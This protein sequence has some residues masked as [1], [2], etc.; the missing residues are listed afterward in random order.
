VRETFELLGRQMT[1]LDLS[2]PADARSPAVVASRWRVHAGPVQTLDGS[3][4]A[5]AG[6]EA[7]RNI[8]LRW[9]M[10]DGVVL[11]LR[12]RCG[13]GPIT[14]R[15]C[16][17]QLDRIEYRLKPYDIVLLR[18][19]PLVA[20]LPPASL[21]ARLGPSA[22]A[23]IVEQGIR[24]IGLDT[25][26]GGI[27]RPGSLAAAAAHSARRTGHDYYRIDGLCNLHRIPVAHGFTVIAVPVLSQPSSGH[28][29]RVVA[30]FD[31][32]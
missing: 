27:E 28:A 12:D 26:S 8:P 16:R 20:E 25:A 30:L 29:S 31:G 15:A 2:R 10:G 3:P 1:V 18:V 19:R 21:H 17:E 23:W 13:E 4:A 5:G 11:D 6:G 24:V 22:L 9:S 7:V 14:E 32:V